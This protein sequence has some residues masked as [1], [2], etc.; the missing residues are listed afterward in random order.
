MKRTRNGIS[1]LLMALMLLQCMAVSALAASGA[2]FSDVAVEAD[3]EAQEITIT[4][5]V[6][7]GSEKQLTVTLKLG[8]DVRYLNQFTS[9]A[10]GTFIHVIP[11][12]FSGGQTFTLVLGGASEQ[13]LETSFTVPGGSS[14]GGG[15]GSTRYTITAKAGIGGTITPTQKVVTRNSD[16]KFVIKANDSYQI[17]D[18]LVDGKSVGAVSTYTFEKVNKNHTIEAQFEPAGAWT[19]P[20][21]DVAENSWYYSAVRFVNDNGLFSGTSAT[22]FAPDMVM[23]RGMLVTVLHRWAGTPESE[24]SDFTDVAA[25]SWYAAAVD[26]AAAEGVVNGVGNGKFDPDGSVTREQIATILYRYAQKTNS[27]LSAKGE[28]GQF[29]DAASVSSFAV[30]GMKWAVGNGLISGKDGG[31]LDPVGNAT[32]AE[33]A[34]IMMRFAE[35]NT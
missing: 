28:L 5:T 24:K 25:G 23:T 7:S 4:G 8:D 2:G 15:S 9:S 34:T 35:K 27:G 14:G 31:I 20:F 17:K 32:R 19:N 18:V 29:K 26:W 3:V 33:V 21:N 16:A 13:A 10:D 11:T 30:D 12:T 22:T 1:I 6:P